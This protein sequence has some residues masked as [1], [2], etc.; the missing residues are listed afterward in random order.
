M[1]ITRRLLGSSAIVSQVPG[2]RDIIVKLDLGGFVRRLLLFDTYVL[3]SVRL[4]EIPELVGH[5]GFEGTISLLSSGALEIRHECAQFVE[6]E[7]KTPPCPLLTYQFHIIEAHVWEQYLI[8]SLPALKTSPELS[9]TEL[10]KLQGA[11]VKAVRRI[12]NKQMFAAEVSPAF[13]SELLGNQKLVKAAVLF[14][15]TERYGID[16]VDF[17]IKIHKVVADDARYQ[18]ETDLPDKLHLSREQIHQAIKEALLGISGLCQRVAEMKGHVA[19][20]GFMEEEL[21]LF[22][23]KLGSLADEMGSK[24]QED[25]F[26]RLISTA[27][28]P[29]IAPDQRIDIEKLLQIRSEP[30]AVEFRAWLSDIDKLSDA[31]LRDRVAGLNARLGL[32]V[33][34]TGGKA[35]RLLAT[36]V[37]G[38]KSPAAGIIAGILDQFLWDNFLR[39]S[40]VAAFANELYPSIF[41]NRAKRGK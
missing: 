2:E 4:K 37:V 5:F 29:E 40:G 34:S 26:L 22:R 16:K 20:S 21:P 25:R 38:I 23:T 36:T 10:M 33:Q 7:F 3:Y 12:D 17:D 31:E 11:V 6:G 19:L 28:I 24:S 27:A 41:A 13:E 39:R 35:L 30:E 1:E 9:A 14:V 18:V 32:A 15:L 8:D